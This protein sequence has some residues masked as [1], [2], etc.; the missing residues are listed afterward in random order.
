M[1]GGVE[2]FDSARTWTPDWVVDVQAEPRDGIVIEDFLPLLRNLYTW[3]KLF[4]RDFWE[5]EG[6]WFREGVAY[7]DQP[8]VT[9]LFAR[10]RTIDV[11]PDVVYRY[12]MRDDQ[13]S[14]S[15]QTASLKDLRQ[16]IEAWEE[17]RRV[18]R[19]GGPRP[20]VRRVVADAVRRPLPL[21][22]AEPRDL[23]RRLLAGAGRRRPVVHR[24]RVARGL[25]STPGPRGAC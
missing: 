24:R 9:Q 23:R 18:L 8:I 11:I 4:R 3:N 19:S 16:R 25:A 20:G 21:V 12:R 5:R 7:E 13:S 15:Q 22:P 1:V 10:A 2:R 6:L 14:I 17:T